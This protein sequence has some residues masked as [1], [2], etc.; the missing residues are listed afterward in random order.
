MSIACLWTPAWRTDEEP[1]APPVAPDVVEAL[2]D[3]VPRVA[4]DGRGMVWADVRGLPLRDTAERLRAAC[5][6]SDDTVRVGVAG[7]PV[8]AEIAARW[9][10]E[11][12]KSGGSPRAVTI[13][14]AGGDRDFLAAAPIALLDP[15]PSLLT[16]LEG[17][18]LTTCG[19]LAVLS[20]EAV[21]VRFGARGAHLWRL[22]RA[23]DPRRL[24]DRIPPLRPHAS[25]DF[26]EYVI[27]DP[28]RLVFTANAL[29]TPICEGLA[30]RGEHAR[31][32]TLT[33]PLANGRAW[34]RTL[35]PGRP[36]ASR[37]IWLRLIRARLERL[38]VP[39]AVT[40]VAVEVGA[41]E[42]A[43]VRQGDLF[44][45]GFGSA[46]AVEA[47]L[48]RLIGE[49]G[50]VVVAPEVDAHPLAERRARWRTRDPIEVAD[51]K[52]ADEEGA[53]SVEPVTVA[54]GAGQV[55]AT[56]DIAGADDVTADDDVP[57]PDAP[58]TLQLL[59][60][61]RDVRVNLEDGQPTRLYDRRGWRV[62]TV[63][64]GP[65]RVSGGWWE[66]DAYAREYYRCVTDEGVL[67]WL[68]RDAA[69]DRWLLQGWWD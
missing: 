28:A 66:D 35:R 36:T 62:L 63:V 8:A 23:D 69:R 15:I 1:P 5:E 67:V 10:E 55:T 2:L 45:R 49:L 53:S 27:T 57:V 25:I 16:L 30:A 6:T 61:P 68:Y 33:L 52:V 22:A 37:D 13:V 39:D 19:A 18:G 38:S 47:A 32:L 17:T 48:S 65:D 60:E 59:P 31:A 50:E 14:P 56:D 21:E 64:A 20:R 58:L 11:R 42:P 51:N 3:V 7:I 12:P 26:I 9:G 40:G 24:F 46:S 29:I 44:D 4:L 41:T 43:G 54:S 34:S